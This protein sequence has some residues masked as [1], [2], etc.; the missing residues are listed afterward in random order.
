[1]SRVALVTTGKLELSGLHTALQIAFAGHQFIPVALPSGEPHHG[2]TSCTVRPLQPDDVL[3]HAAALLQAA[4]EVLVPEEPVALVADLAIVLDDLEL[5]NVGNEDQ[6][7]GHMRESARRVIADARGAATP[8]RVATLLR[9]RVSFHLAVPMVESWL[10]GDH[11][12]LASEVPGARLP[13]RLEEGRDPED[14]LVVDPAYLADDGSDCLRW[15]AIGQP[16]RWKPGW[17][18]EARERHP[19]HYLQW[20]FK[21]ATQASC[22]RFMETQEGARILERLSWG[23][24]LSNPAWYP[25]LRA[26]MDDISQCLGQPASGVS[27]AGVRASRT[28]RKTGSGFV[29]RNI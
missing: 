12:A 18:K 29:L 16:S 27:D 14:F 1:M 24:V 20:L 17:L 4:L 15:H 25:Y 26:M 21:D 8:D 6:V 3:S 5:E 22:A 10:F 13:T 23:T 9:E 19:K 7:I 11:S 2:F 28:A